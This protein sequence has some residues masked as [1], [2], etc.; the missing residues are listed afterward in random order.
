MIILGCFEGTTILGNPHMLP[1]WLLFLAGLRHLLTCCNTPHSYS[2]PWNLTLSS[3]WGLVTADL[4]QESWARAHGPQFLNHAFPWLK[5]PYGMLYLKALSRCHDARSCRLFSTFSDQHCYWPKWFV[6][7]IIC[8]VTRILA[9]CN[10]STLAS[11]VCSVILA[12]PNGTVPFVL[13]AQW[14]SMNSFI[15]NLSILSGVWDCV[16][17]LQYLLASQVEM[18]VL[19]T[20][21]HIY[22]YDCTWVIWCCKWYKSHMPIQ[23]HH[24]WIIWNTTNT[25]IQNHRQADDDLGH[26]CRKE[27]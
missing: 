2:N 12:Q 3:K 9:W 1:F 15:Y 23:Q 6:L 16:L 8:E 26:R 20:H 27:R 11:W 18:D 5:Q 13:S 7:S 14:F 4:F 24:P 21:A 17:Q 19:N 10:K 25:T 22:I